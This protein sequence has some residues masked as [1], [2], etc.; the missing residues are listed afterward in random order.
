LANTNKLGLR[1]DIHPQKTTVKV[2]SLVPDLGITRAFGSDK[3]HIEH[4]QTVL[5]ALNY[6][7]RDTVYL[8]FNAMTINY[9]GSSAGAIVRLR[10]H[11]RER[12]GEKDW[13]RTMVFFLTKPIYNRSIREYVENTI[14][15]RLSAR[16]FRLLQTAPAFSELN[17]DNGL[18]AEQHILEIERILELLDT[19]KPSETNIQLD[20]DTTEDVREDVKALQNLMASEKQ[21]FEVELS[22][23]NTQAKG[24][25]SGFGLEV[26][27]GSVGTANVQDHMKKVDAFWRRREELEQLGVIEITDEVLCF[28][29]NHTFSSPTAAAQILTGSNRPGPLVWKREADGKTLKEITG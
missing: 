17:P 5:D 15:T 8:L 28:T 7:D 14:Y 25:Y 18:I 21:S 11:C 13:D 4:L 24:R 12:T 3:E 26:Y 16:G 10:T 20:P 27:S 29:E 1:T 6:I 2:Y 9:V 19:A 22:Y 23:P